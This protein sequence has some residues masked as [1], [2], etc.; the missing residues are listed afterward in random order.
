MIHDDWGPG[1]ERKFCQ[2]EAPLSLQE[3]A[4]IA[5]Y[6]S[7]FGAA[8]QGGDIVAP[9]AY[10]ASLK[11]L[12]GEGRQV[13]MLWQHDAAQPIGV[14]DEVREDARG[15]FVKGRLLAEVAKGREAAALVAAGAI[16]GLSI[17]YRTRRA[18][19]DASGRRLLSELE[20]WEVSLV[21]FPMLPEAR[22]G[23]K[24]GDGAEALWREMAEALEGA[25]HVLAGA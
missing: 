5:G 18:S 11:R 4:V 14:W 25:R 22:V 15:L 8:D 3:G 1:L 13:K 9:G 2:P 17:G 10:A 12:A 19:K 6:A 24:A 20:L 7:L 21:T 23:A 16:D